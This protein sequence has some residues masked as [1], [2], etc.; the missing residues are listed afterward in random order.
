MGRVGVEWV[1]Q[2]EEGSCSK[3][4]LKMIVLRNQDLT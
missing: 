1:I 3:D 2:G 4:N